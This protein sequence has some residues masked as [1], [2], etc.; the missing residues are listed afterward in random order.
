MKK[1]RWLLLDAD[2]TLFDFGRCE[3]DALS[4][5]LEAAGI[6]FD[7]RVLERYH[8]INDAM[9]KKLELGL[10]KKEDLKY[11][12]FDE[13]LDGLCDSGTDAHALADD[14][15]DRLSSFGWLLP[16]AMEALERLS[17]H[18][19]LYIITNGVEFIQRRRI[20][21][22]GILPL[23][24]G[25]FISDVIGVEK[26]GAGFFDAVAAGIPGFDRDLALVVGDSLSSDIKGG[27]AYGI[28]TCWVNRKGAPLPENCGMITYSVP[29]IG[30]LPELLGC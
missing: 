20:G 4:G 15:M 7:D 17:G 24:D 12:R 11:R 8:V 9:W 13:F 27:A 28:D 14:Y 30:A 22:S 23:L 1:Y 29:G 18:F 19:G 26:P 6:S 5:A 2:E 10:I 25:V 3:R 16:G 21:E